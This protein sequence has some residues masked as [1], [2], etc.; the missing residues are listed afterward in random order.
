MLCKEGPDLS[1]VVQCKTARTSSFCNVIFESQLVIKNYTKTYTRHYTHMIVKLFGCT[2][3]HNKAQYKCIIH[4]SSFKENR[5]AG[6][7][8]RTAPPTSRLVSGACTRKSSHFWCWSNPPQVWSWYSRGS[9]YI[10]LTWI[11]SATR[12]YGGVSTVSNIVCPECIN[13]WTLNLQTVNNPYPL[14]LV[15]AALEEL[16]SSPKWTCK[17]PTTS[18]ESI[19]ET[20][21]RRPSSHLL[22]TMTIG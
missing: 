21:G 2:A 20:S 9:P 12:S 1:D 11:G 15:P 4:S 5:W 7:R 8:L 6:A 19:L 10:L 14:L 16:A 3:I 17:A 22:A 13:Y 18:F